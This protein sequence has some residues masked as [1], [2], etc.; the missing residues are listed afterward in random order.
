VKRDSDKE[1]EFL[2]AAARRM[3][4]PGVRV[5]RGPDWIWQNQGESL[6]K[7]LCVVDETV[8]MKREREKRAG[9]KDKHV[10]KF[11][12]ISGSNG[13]NGNGCR[14]SPTLSP[15]FDRIV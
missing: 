7:A 8:K 13:H 4:A 10:N 14:F 1:E 3:I 6:L 12:I 5:V 11:H 15:S 2:Q 9:K